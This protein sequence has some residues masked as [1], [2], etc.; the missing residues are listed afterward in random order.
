MEEAVLEGIGCIRLEENPTA[1]SL[2]DLPELILAK[3]C[4]AVLVPQ[5]VETSPKV[6]HG[7]LKHRKRFSMK[8]YQE[9]E[10]CLST[11]RSLRLSCKLIHGILLQGATGIRWAG[12]DR[13]ASA[14]DC[15]PL[16]L[17]AK[18]PAIRR[19][20]LKGVR[21]PPS[22]LFG[23][24]TSTNVLHCWGSEKQTRAHALDFTP[25]APSRLLSRHF[26]IW[27]LATS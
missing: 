24:P 12:L 21:N 22:T 11:Q 4:Q 15:P 5:P 19:L 25:L 6:T 17:L 10:T 18:C 1:V 8:A 2:P 20:D 23:L 16:A 26:K 9:R 3:I 7:Y 27:T 14:A 13:D